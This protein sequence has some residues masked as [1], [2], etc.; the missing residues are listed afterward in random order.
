MIV[1]PGEDLGIG[2]VCEWVVGE[3]GLPTLVGLI[4]FEADVGRP[5][6]FL[7]FGGDE[8]VTLQCPVDRRGV[9][10]DLVVVFEMPADRVRASI[11]PF[12]LETAAIFED[13]RDRRYVDRVR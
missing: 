12:D 10:L 7:G 5:W 2:P 1:E 13:Q 3:V 11:E 9:D 8:P 4:G 6:S